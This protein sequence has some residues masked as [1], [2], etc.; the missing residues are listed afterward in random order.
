MT[1]KGIFFFPDVLMNAGG[2]TVSYFEWLKN[3]D[4]TRP[5]RLTKK[6]EEKSKLNLLKAAE[7]LS[8][9]KMKPIGPEES[10]LLAGPSELDMVRSG[11]ENV[12][13]E[14][15]HKLIQTSIEKNTD[16]RTAAFYN[17][18]MRVHNHYVITGSVH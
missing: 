14:A 2:V 7:R 9:M 3:L 17:A 15:A 6:W 11:L 12:M 8:G 1:K 13:I 4:H 5:G 16:L 18:I 10:K